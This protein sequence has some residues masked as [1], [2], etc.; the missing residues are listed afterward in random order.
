[1]NA[2]KLSESNEILRQ[3]AIVARTDVRKALEVL[4]MGLR[5]ARKGPEARVVSSLARHAG[6]MCTQL[7]DIREA[8]SYYEEA[9]GGDPQDAYLHFAIGDLW[10]RLGQHDAAR[11][12]FIRSLELA[13]QQAD[14]DMINMASKA[15][16]RLD[17]ERDRG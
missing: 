1:M 10:R 2:S 17:D 16:A 12:A 3:A 15:R 8:L 9:L 7:G 14:D 11:S 4:E 6:V 13:T 5:K